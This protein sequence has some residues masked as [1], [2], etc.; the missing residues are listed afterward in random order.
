MSNT[1]SSN[2]DNLLGEA[3]FVH[4]LARALAGNDADEVVQ[5]TWLRT[6]EDG[7]E[8]IRN[9]RNWLASV[10]RGVAHNLRRGHTRRQ[11]HERAAAERN[12]APSPIALMERQELRRD[13]LDAVSALPAPQRTV[14]L[15]RHFEGLPPRRIA[16]HLG[17]PLTTV[18]SRLRTAH[19][20]LRQRLDSKH[21]GRTAWLLAL[22]PA[23]D[24]TT[25]LGLG[26]LAMTIKT[27]LLIAVSV[28]LLATLALWS[29]DTQPP[30]APPGASDP[31]TPPP[32]LAHDPVDHQAN[33]PDAPQR[34][35]VIGNEPALPPTTGTLIVKAIYTEDGTPAPDLLILAR[36]PGADRRFGSHL[37]RTDV[38][39]I[40]RIEHLEPGSLF[41]TNSRNSDA[42]ARAEVVAGE[43]T[44]IELGLP[45][46]V[47][48][49]GVVVDHLAVPVL[50]AE[51]CLAGAG[52]LEDAQQAATTGPDGRFAL[53]GCASMCSVGARAAGHSSSK[54]EFVTM[55]DGSVRDLRLVLPA[56]GGTVAG[57][58]SDLTRV[59]IAGAVV[60][61][62]E[63]SRVRLDMTPDGALRAMV[64]TDSE[65]RFRAVGLPVGD[66]P[67]HVRAAG[68]APWRGSCRVE[69]S[70][71]TAFDVT[72]GTAMSCVGIVVDVDGS[73]VPQAT[74]EIGGYDDFEHYRT[75]SAEDGTFRLD[76]LSP[77][78]IEVNA[79]HK[80]AGAD[81]LQIRGGPGEA[82]RCELRLEPGLALRGRVLSE[83]NEPIAE[84]SIDAST[85]Y[86]AGEKGWGR[87]T[88]AG[89]SG[90][91]A[92]LQCPEGKRLTVT[93]NA[94][95]FRPSVIEDVDPRRGDIAVQMT[96]APAR[97]AYIVGTIIT[98]DGTPVPQARLVARERSSGSSS[99]TAADDSGRFS[100]GPLRAGTWSVAIR[101]PEQ[102]TTWTEWREISAAAKVNLGQIRLPVA[103]TIHVRLHG[104]GEL[105]LRVFASDASL[106]HWTSFNG[107]GRE[108]RSKPLAPGPHYVWVTGDGI[109]AHLLLIEVRESE[110]REI[111]IK[112]QRG[113]TQQFEFIAPKFMSERHIRILQ[114]GQLVAGLSA[115]GR[116]P[117]QGDPGF[118]R[119]LAPGDYTIT[120]NGNDM[121]G[122]SRFTVGESNN[123]VVRVILR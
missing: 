32:L 73:P 75:I 21:G 5:G 123:E 37:V 42:N 33:E 23:R 60:T 82:V 57:T 7:A 88:T 122:K 30:L 24:G 64:R 116:R 86:T 45:A 101:V 80:A 106:A 87:W 72:L 66:H 120:V 28:M 118:R 110:E 1:S 20:T 16:E 81:R 11:G 78:A 22:L 6:M 90:R 92:I 19:A 54:M 47:T 91:F 50:G 12:P 2:I 48:I 94:P 17:A 109:A 89:T 31:I 52:T 93:V 112:V 14:V 71:E 9:P 40:A 65:G 67:V 56:A 26:V 99:N 15:L 103:G 29:L 68:K 41:V 55:Q 100:V 105:D 97:S 108:R 46:G 18:T 4:A 59:P 85:V 121:S 69:A 74:V 58:I 83:D 111:E 115:V 62:G 70:A 27:K 35:S 3:P 107:E 13:L 51:V 44:E 77:G 117:G 61:I 49:T 113:H 63:Q 34:S 102:P 114:N 8:T 38:L 95:G 25:P 36:Q 10:V 104:A 76:G 98:S 43:V 53:R 119:N 84:A 39:G 79:R 96:P